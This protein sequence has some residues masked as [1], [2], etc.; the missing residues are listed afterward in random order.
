M[1]QPDGRPLSAADIQSRTA[2]VL[3]DRF[4][5]L[6]SVAEALEQLS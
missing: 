3:K 6:C 2:T 1:V 5:R 4:A